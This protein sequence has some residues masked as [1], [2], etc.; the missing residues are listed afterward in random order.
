MGFGQAIATCFR[1]YVDF[2]GY[3]SR[4]EYW[5]WT[6]FTVLVAIAT[7]LLD[8]ALFSS[9][10]ADSISDW[11]PLNTLWSLAIL[12]PN[13]AVFVRRLRDAGFAWPW[14]FIGLVP[15]AGALI[16]LVFVLMPSKPRFTSFPGYA[17]AQ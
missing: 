1:K 17:P 16:L 12:L 7:S 5:W 10:P 6:L 3:A 2:R 14:I 15:I 9:S 11:T 13:L 8:V 4:S